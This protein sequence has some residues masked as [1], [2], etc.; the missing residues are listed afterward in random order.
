MAANLLL[1]ED[2]PLIRRSLAA[3]LRRSGHEV[4]EVESV[5]DARHAI[6]AHNFDAVLVDYK[7]PDGTGFEVMATVEEQSGRPPCVMLTAHASVEHAVEAMRRGAYTYLQKPVDPDELDM[8]VKKALETGDLR[9]ENR[10]LKRLQKSA[11]NADS[12]Q[13]ISPAAEEIRETIRQVAASPAQT[14]LIQGESGTGKGLVARALHGESL[15]REHPFVSIT[16]SAV[17]DTLLESELFGHE[18]GAFTDARKRKIG[19]LEAADKGTLFLDEIGD[20]PPGLQAKLLGVLED[21][22]FRRIG[23]VKEIR[24]NVRT[25]SATHQ[26]LDKLVG[27]GR[28]RKDLLYRLRVI[29][30][31]IP[32]LRDR[33]E[34]VS[35]LAQ[36]FAK[37]LAGDWGRRELTLTQ[38]AL[39][40]LSTRS[41]PGNVRELRNAI[42]R[43]VILAR[44]NRLDAS[45]FR[46]EP[47][48]SDSIISLPPEGIN[49][50]H[51]I[52]E[53][54][55][56]A[57]DRTGG[58]QSAAARLLG[59]SRDQVRYRMAKL[60]LLARHGAAHA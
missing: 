12:F 32:P 1:V 31:H 29:P 55:R 60:G 51:V 14:I 54:L 35:V 11:I 17:P 25:I 38:D 3:R 42:E 56:K 41:W 50:E 20:M 23:G 24:V 19:L 48:E 58:N 18:P 44:G 9:R 30:M 6:G 53:L 15:R 33:P 27:E 21:R 2:D 26:N 47:T 13:G 59:L 34:D 36:Q 43:A 39:D 40:H 52:D 22:A 4:D 37:D 45:C 57:L 10:R 28:F 5:A 49:V 16:C 7:L 8:Q 46:E